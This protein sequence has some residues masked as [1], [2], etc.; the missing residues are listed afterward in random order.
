[1][2]EELGYVVLVTN[3]RKAYLIYADKHKTDKLD[4]QRTSPVWPGWIP[5]FFIRF[6]AP[7]YG[8]SQAHLAILRSREAFMG[9][10]T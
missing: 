2:P 9:A 4:A 3:L 6:K 8:F 7:G 5:S 1:L 10:R